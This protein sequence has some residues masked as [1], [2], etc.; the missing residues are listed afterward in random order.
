MNELI[1]VLFDF[2]H[3]NLTAKLMILAIM[4]IIIIN[5]S[6]MLL[7]ELAF[8]MPEFIMLQNSYIPNYNSNLLDVLVHYYN[9]NPIVRTKA[10]YM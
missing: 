7:H 9:H 2:V 4:A 5:K 6:A 8:I 1:V 10:I 3:I